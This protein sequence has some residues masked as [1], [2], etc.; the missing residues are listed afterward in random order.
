MHCGQVL[1]VTVLFVVFFLSLVLCVD[2][3]RRKKIV[4]NWI[5]KCFV[6]LNSIWITVSLS[7]FIRITNATNYTALKTKTSAKYQSK[8][9][10]VPRRWVP[11]IDVLMCFFF[12]FH[13]C[14][15]VWILWTVLASILVSYY[16]SQAATKGEKFM[17]HIIESQTGGTYMLGE[18]DSVITTKYTTC[19]QSSTRAKFTQTHARRA[20]KHYFVYENNSEF[21]KL[22]YK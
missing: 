7:E 3:E 12:V 21:T 16:L 2:F 17:F 10:A 11:S 22:I 5:R 1:I 6:T 15:L 8:L 18:Y 4:W 13:H 9:I 20:K 19:L 14:T